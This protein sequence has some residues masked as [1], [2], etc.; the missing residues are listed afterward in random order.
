MLRRDRKRLRQLRPRPPPDP[1]KK[2][3][4]HAGLIRRL[5]GFWLFH[6]IIGGDS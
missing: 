1:E 3:A 5:F 6:K 2:R 4:E